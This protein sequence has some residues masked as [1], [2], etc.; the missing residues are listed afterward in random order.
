MMLDLQLFLD[1]ALKAGATDEK[2]NGILSQLEK[3]RVR[4]Q[5]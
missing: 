5:Y 2:I 3:L 1:M 4:G